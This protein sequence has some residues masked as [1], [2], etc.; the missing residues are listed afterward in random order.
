MSQNFVLKKGL[1]VPI[2]GKA[3]L[4]ISNAKNP[5]VVAVQ[6]SLFKGLMPRLL[7]KEGD[8]VMCG[9]PVIADKSHPD[10]LLTSPVSGTVK[11]IVRGEKRKL[12][13]VLIE[14]NHEG[15]SVEFSLPANA[16]A[17]EVR[18]LLL[19]SGMWPWFVQRPYGI[20]ANPDVKPRSIFVS[21][22]N[23]APMAPDVEFCFTNEIRFIQAAVSAISKL[24]DGGVHVSLDAGNYSS[25]PLHKLED[26]TI[27]TFSGKHPAG[28]VGVQISHICPI[29]KDETVWTIS[30]L[31]LA[32]IGRLIMGKKVDL[33]RRVAVCGPNAIDPSYIETLPG[34]PM[35]DI[36]GQVG[37]TP[38]ITRVISGDILT[39]ANVGV[40]GYLGFYDNQISLLKEGNEKE[41][42]GWIR[43]FRYKQFSTDHSYFSWL[44]PW[45]KYN[46]DTNL[47]GGPRAFIMNDAYYGK[48]LPM[49][50]YP[51]YLTKACIAG[52]IEKM[53]KFGIY[54]VLPEDL[55]VCEF[56]DPSKNN[57]QDI[58][59][60]GID[61][62]LKEMA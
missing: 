49:D 37:N 58:I 9:S 4:R 15:E 3:E 53:E 52:D 12:L 21:G 35:S 30:L 62:M 33:R 20:I 6:P 11:S 13:A 39:G 17:E 16:G 2:K 5:N 48:V 43:P 25:T 28:N 8:A 46:I 18:R 36:L 54:E 1:D 50:I 41:Y 22:F 32:A 19:S 7:V 40:D 60:K 59:A 10:I 55:A 56:V 31:G 26:C 24:T 44:T 42:F 14:N 57:I 38:E 29:R 61:L 34:M 45:R 47:H 23:T 27:H 51:L